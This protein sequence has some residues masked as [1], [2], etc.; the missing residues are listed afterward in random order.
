VRIALL[1][2]HGPKNN[3]DIKL[4]YAL[5]TGSI[6]P[7]AGV[8]YQPETWFDTSA[9]DRLNRGLFSPFAIYSPTQDRSKLPFDAVMA[10]LG[11]GTTPG[12]VGASGPWQ[13][14]GPGKSAYVPTT[15]AAFGPGPVGPSLISDPISNAQNP[16]AFI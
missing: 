15:A 2:L 14:F 10:S 11:S 5:S 3:E 12:V 1:R 6:K 13:G 8:L 9:Q 7:P 16:S 4:L